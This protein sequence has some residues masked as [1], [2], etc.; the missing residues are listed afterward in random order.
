MN[1]GESAEHM[2]RLDSGGHGLQGSLLVVLLLLVSGWS[3]MASLEHD[4]ISELS[5][6][7]VFWVE[8]RA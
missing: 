7:K 5:P 3:G 2:G 8:A 6:E 1:G 4:D